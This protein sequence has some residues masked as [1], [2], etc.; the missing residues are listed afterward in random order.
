VKTS[1]RIEKLQKTTSPQSLWIE[2]FYT[3][4]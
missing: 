3:I 1:Y 2:S 4:I